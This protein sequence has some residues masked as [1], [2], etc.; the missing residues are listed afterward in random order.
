MGKKLINGLIILVLVFLS[1]KSDPT[2]PESS[3]DLIPLAVGNKWVFLNS[4]LNPDGSLNFSSRDSIEF[5]ADTTIDGKKWVY[6]NTNGFNMGFNN[7]SEGVNVRLLSPNTP[8]DIYLYF[9]GLVHKNIGYGFPQL[10][11]YGSTAKLVDTLYT[12]TLLNADTTISTGLGSFRCGQFRVIENNNI[13]FYRDI[14][15]AKGKGWIK[16]EEYRWENPAYW[17]RRSNEVTKI[18]LH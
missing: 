16:V 5:I 7:T 18:V 4:V 10:Q 9:P 8:N 1:C 14:Y 3:N 12:I 13:L 17:K 2:G 11:I 6:Q 15:L